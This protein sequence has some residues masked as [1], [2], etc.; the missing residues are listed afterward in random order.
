[1]RTPKVYWLYV[2]VATCSALLGI[3]VYKYGF[4]TENYHRA[5]PWW[6][7]ISV[8]LATVLLLGS[9]PIWMRSSTTRNLLN[10]IAHVLLMGTGVYVLAQGITELIDKVRKLGR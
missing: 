2:G 9:M 10:E 7:S 1:M 6:A 5:G 4:P 8:G 3:A